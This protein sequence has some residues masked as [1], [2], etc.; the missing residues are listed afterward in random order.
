LN[1]AFSET[2]INVC[3]GRLQIN[4]PSTHHFVCNNARH[5][6]EP[7][8]CGYIWVDGRT[9]GRRERERERERGVNGF[10]SIFCC[11]TENLARAIL[12]S[13]K[14]PSSTMRAACL[15][16]AVN[17]IESE[18]S[19]VTSNFPLLLLI[20]MPPLPFLLSPDAYCASGSIRP[21]VEC[22]FY[23]TLADNSAPLCYLFLARNLR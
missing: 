6:H 17:K 20:G 16:M 7:E 23:N 19:C 15:T 10:P 12:I 2:Q 11:E 1:R 18:L 4:Y 9:E 22:A 3:T 14:N 5:T 8:M 13:E 21:R